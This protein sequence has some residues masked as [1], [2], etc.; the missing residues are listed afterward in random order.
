MRIA[1][2]ASAACLGIACTPVEMPSSLVVSRVAAGEALLGSADD[3]SPGNVVHVWRYACS[4]RHPS[5]CGYHRVGDGVV[6]VVLLDSPHYAL[7]QFVPGT[8]VAPG[9]HASK[10]FPVPSWSPDGPYE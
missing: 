9:D 5:R 7:I 4:G 8:S 6:T 1:A 10:D 2:L 3:L